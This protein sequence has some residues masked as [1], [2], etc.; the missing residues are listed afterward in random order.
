MKTVSIYQAKSTLSKLIQDIEQ[1]LEP[2]I[3]IARG[4]R[5]VARLL[6]L[7]SSPAEKR[8]GRA[9]GL[10]EV[11][12]DIDVLNPEIVRL[13]IGTNDPEPSA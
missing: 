5:P 6:P 9:K 10:F 11:P 3:I 4:S 8:I 7:E 12:D 2:E 1:G 13:F